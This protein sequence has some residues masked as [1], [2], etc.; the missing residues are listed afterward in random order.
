VSEEDLERLEKIA[1]T[2]DLVEKKR[3]VTTLR[4]LNRRLTSSKLRSNLFAS[5][6]PSVWHLAIHDGIFR[7]GSRLDSIP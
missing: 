4:Y 2:I 7:Q 6:H 1:D 3:P 5:K